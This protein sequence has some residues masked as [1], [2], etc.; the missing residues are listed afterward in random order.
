VGDGRDG[1]IGPRRAQH[2]QP[3]GTRQRRAT[4]WL[5]TTS[6]MPSHARI[7]NSSLS[8]R[9]ATRNQPERAGPISR[10]NLQYSKRVR[11]EQIWR[12]I[13][14]TP[15]DAK[16]NAARGVVRK[17][18]GIDLDSEF[19]NLRVARDLRPQHVRHLVEREHRAWWGARR[20]G[21]AARPQLPALNLRYPSQ[22]IY[23]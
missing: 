5:V 19:L 3:N 15:S 16:A 4:C 8:C 22:P 7:M 1:G 13:Q 14:P 12:L 18:E 11:E 2:D 10:R 23:Q 21:L 6:Q 9:T 17:G 20:D